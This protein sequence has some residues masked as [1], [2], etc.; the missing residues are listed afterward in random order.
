MSEAHLQ[1]GIQ[2]ETKV[3]SVY[4]LNRRAR[5]LLEGHFQNIWVEGEISNFKHHSSG[6]MYLSLKDDKAQISA[7]F[8]SRYNQVVKFEIKDGLK[9]LA[10]G[11][12]SLYES[13]GQYQLYIERLE[14]KGVGALQ[15]AFLQLKEKLEKE[16]LFSR[17]HKKIIPKFPSTVGVVTSPTGAAI[18]DILNVVNRRFGG[19]NILLYPVKVQG[20]GAAEEIAQAI[21]EMNRMGQ[22]DVMIVGRGGGSLE[23][24]WA[25]NEEV[26]AREVFASKI[27]IISAVGH[28]IDWTICDLVA[29]LRAPTP[30]AAAELVVQNREELQKRVENSQVRL[31]NA[32][33]NLTEGWKGSLERILES[34]AFRQ[35]AILIQQFSQR[36]DELLRQLQNYWRSYVSQKGQ[37]FQSLVG[38]L[39]A[40]SPLGVLE[41]G[42]SLNFDSR[43][44]VLK[45][46]GQVKIGDEIKTR[47]HRGLLH[48]KVTKVEDRE[49]KRDG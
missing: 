17:D 46:A 4:E 37:A 40:L 42:Y 39:H 45:E 27:P 49:E 1:E 18:R 28:E 35:P 36:I 41:R 43:G 23:D 22:V 5:M 16:G 32:M 8:F 2:K 15:L 21:R 31:R 29:D 33:V 19:T 47:L 25:F 20:E 6:H 26:V 10:C 38:K 34:Y 11:K 12:I 30:S 7:V 24:L 3:Y 9:V 44:K 48:S 14:P 13:R